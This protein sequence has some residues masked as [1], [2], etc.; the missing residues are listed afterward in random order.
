MTIPDASVPF[1]VASVLAVANALCA[2]AVQR[3]A[4]EYTRAK[5]SAL[6]LQGGDARAFEPPGHLTPEAVGTIAAWAADAGPSGV[7]TVSP[8]VAGLLLLH[9][10]PSWLVAVYVFAGLAGLALFVWTLFATP[11]KY[12]DRRWYGLTI[13][14]GVGIVLN[15]VL[16]VVVGCVS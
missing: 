15:A 16:A 2:W 3:R 11:V 4:E 13:V 6:L 8:L 5:D 10:R 9:D 14:S 12:V 7:I 1:A